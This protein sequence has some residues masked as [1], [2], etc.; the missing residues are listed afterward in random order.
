MYRLSPCKCVIFCVKKKLNQST[1]HE[2]A[3]KL[4][5][6]I[7]KYGHVPSVINVWTKYGESRMHDKGQTDLI[8][9]T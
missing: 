4:R 2:T 7:K 3:I 8:I 5:L 1:Y 6:Q 9:K